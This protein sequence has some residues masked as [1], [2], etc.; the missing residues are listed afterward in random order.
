MFS[1]HLNPQILKRAPNK[2]GRLLPI[3]RYC[4]NA[5]QI[6]NFAYQKLIYYMST[7]YVQMIY[8]IPA[9]AL[10]FLQFLFPALGRLAGNIARL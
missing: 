5:T 9:N 7:T 10:A 2:V 6:V 1:C 4:I 8:P 3:K